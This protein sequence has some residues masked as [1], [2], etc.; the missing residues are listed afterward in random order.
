MRVGLALLSAFNTI[1]SLAHASEN[2]IEAPYL[3]AATKEQRYLVD[4]Y[5]EVLPVLDRFPMLRDTL[6][7]KSPRLCLS[8]QMDNA[9]AYLDVDSNQIVIGQSLSTA[10]QIGFLFHELRHLWQY[11][12]GTCPSDDLA[13]KDY[14]RA[15]FAI[16]ADASAISLLVAWDMKEHGQDAVW[17]AL[18][19]WSNQSDIATSFEETILE[20]GDAGLAT[21]TAF[22]QWYAKSE[23]QESYYTAV[24]SD[25]LD[26]Q[27]ASHLIPRY[28]LIDVG[29]FDELCRLPDGSRYQ[30]SE[31]SVAPNE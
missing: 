8:D 20:S 29:F 16:E 19:S 15:T 2:C 27:D 5:R 11:S 7:A 14:A 12:Q 21:T 13:M 6:E 31:P 17:N 26:R 3:T 24:C 18:S 28:Q 4:I 30:C 10:L 1:P 23:R 9:H 22:Y 25:Y